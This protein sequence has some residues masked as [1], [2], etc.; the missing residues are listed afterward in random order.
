MRITTPP[1]T[2]CGKSEQ[3]GKARYENQQKVISR[4]HARTDTAINKVIYNRGEN[5]DSITHVGLRRA[6]QDYRQS[7]RA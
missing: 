1:C 3:A 2:R 6:F 7:A 4:A 5:I